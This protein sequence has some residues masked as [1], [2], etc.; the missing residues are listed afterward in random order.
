MRVN[1][2]LNIPN[3]L[4]LTR[5]VMT[6]IIIYLLLREEVKLALL[7]LLLA[8]V[9][10]MLDGAIARFFDQRT[11]VGAYLDPLADKL[12]LIGTMVTL[13]YLGVVPLFLFLAVLFRDALIVLGAISYEL[14]THNLKMEPSM[15]SKA[16]TVSQIL[17][18]LLLICNMAWPINDLVIS[19]GVWLAFILTVASG[20]HYLVVWTEKAVSATA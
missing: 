15:I 2:L 9:S 4:T 8:G 11:I 5:I 14:V 18:L 20:L 7:L 6:P 19:I 16:T 17:S 3:I 1:R 13:F 10:D 12:M